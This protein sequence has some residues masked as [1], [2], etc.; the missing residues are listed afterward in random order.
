MNELILARLHG[1][2]C[3]DL[4]PSDPPHLVWSPDF[5]ITDLHPLFQYQDRL[6]WGTVITSVGMIKYDFWNWAPAYT[7]GSIEVRVTDNHIQ[8]L[9]KWREY[10]S[11]LPR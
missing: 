2:Q 10:G 1:I 4:V 6:L 9:Q 8:S 3:V 7:I 11:P 5:L